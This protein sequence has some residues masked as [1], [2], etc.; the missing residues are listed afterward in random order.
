MY[1]LEIS[2]VLAKILLYVGEWK[3]VKETRCENE[4]DFY[5]SGHDI[6]WEMTLDSHRYFNF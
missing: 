3:C 2:T 4:K 5:S 1:W 6:V